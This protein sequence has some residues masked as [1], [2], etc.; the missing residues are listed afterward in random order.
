M[1]KLQRLPGVV[2]VFASRPPS[3]PGQGT[4][5]RTIERLGRPEYW[6]NPRQLLERLKRSAGLAG[7][8]CRTAWALPLDPGPP[9]IIA[10]D[11]RM[12]GVFDPAVPELIIRLLDPGE[13]GVDVGAHCG[14]NTS[15]MAVAAGPKGK[16][17]A[18]EPHHQMFRL[19]DANRA[20]WAAFECA[21]VEIIQSAVT[22][23]S[24]RAI[25]HEGRSLGDSTLLPEAAPSELLHGPNPSP[26]TGL[27][28]P[29]LTLDESLTRPITI[30]VLKIDVEGCE[31]AVLE[32]AS[33]LLRDGAIRDVIFEDY[34]PKPSPVGTF[35]E[36]HGFEVFGVY[37]SRRGITLVPIAAANHYTANCVATRDRERLRARLTAPGWQCLRT[38]VACR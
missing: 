10:T 11:L 31:L 14:Q 37:P 20:Q 18:F 36:K 35:L 5:A 15:M 25:L 24:G 38:R 26:E 34:A 28:V 30:G 2:E 9:S 6:C 23:A 16:V 22:N 27:Q 13:M 1:P 19:L 7:T 33:G 21:P 32:G 8:A 29:T 17:L 12:L 3:K 4:L